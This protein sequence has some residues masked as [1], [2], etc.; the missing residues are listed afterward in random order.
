MEKKKIFD[1]SFDMYFHNTVN[2]G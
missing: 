1:V 2:L